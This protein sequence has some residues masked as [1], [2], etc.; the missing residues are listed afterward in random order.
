MKSPSFFDD[1]QRSGYWTFQTG[2]PF[3]KN[4]IKNKKTAISEADSG[5]K[6]LMIFSTFYQPAPVWTH[7]TSTTYSTIC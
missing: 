4:V 3:L 7:K 5:F 1:Y 2:Q 6:F